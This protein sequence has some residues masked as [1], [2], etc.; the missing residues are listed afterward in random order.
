MVGL[1]QARALKHT[2][3]PPGDAGCGTL[4]RPRA[5][6]SSSG[7]KPSPGPETHSPPASPEPTKRGCQSHLGPPACTGTG[8]VLLERGQ[9]T[10]LQVTR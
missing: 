5:T 6:N 10:L 9:G 8:S 3:G 2:K 4:A 1:I 7:R